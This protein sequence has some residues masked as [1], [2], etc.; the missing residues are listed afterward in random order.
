MPSEILIGTDLGTT[1]LKAAAFDARTRDVLARASLPL[2]AMNGR[3]G[4]REQ[5]PRAI[6]A[7][8]VDAFAQLRA[9]LGAAWREVSGIG[10]AAQGGSG[11]IVRRTDAEPL[12]PMMLWN[13]SR[14]AR[15]LQDV[16][17]EK[18]AEYWRGLALREGP[19]AG[20]G[21][22][23][24]LR[25]KQPELFCDENIYV[26]AGEYAYFLMTGVWRQDAGSAHQIGCYNAPERRIDP[27]PLAM[28]DL[29]SSF[30]A[31]LREG[32]EMHPV[33]KAG[34][35]L[36]GLP[37]GIAVAGP[38]FDH[39]AGYL[40]ALGVSKRPL[41]CSLGT[42][43][44]G[45][46]TVATYDNGWS[47]TQLVVPDPAGA[48][49]LVAQPLL[50]GNV[51]WNWALETFVYDDHAAALAELETLFSEALLPPDGLIALPWLTQLNA[52]HHDAV[53]A[54]GFYGVSTHTRPR[55][56][57]RAVAA[58]LA[59]EFARVFADVI[60][61]DAVDSVVLGGGAS[62]GSFFRKLFAALCAPLP[63]H[64]LKHQDMAG[65]RGALHAFDGGIAR[66]E[67][68]P[69]PAVQPRLRRRIRRSS[70]AYNK[71]FRRLHG[72]LVCGG[73]YVFRASPNKDRA[74]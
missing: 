48:G 42:A 29:P 8:L 73:P 4:A 18:P 49:W 35:A 70:A 28:V 17:R 41:Q 74:E 65:A 20:L 72:R 7:A 69:V 2:E 54:G 47:P 55:D 46:F 45:N 40:S 25:E 21:R 63:V 39:E 71:L 51:A 66:A 36:F 11:I 24:W 32:H 64:V 31:P 13:D 14:G 58:G 15:R 50:T 33:S 9:A 67:A 37:G 10:L 44:V 57:V 23:L 3:D 12:T 52:L 26:G 22:M 43:W 5:D 38:Y 30:V 61:S 19:G 6:K 56:F 60:V 1:N 53:G 16:A 68:V 34:A 59:C 62:N 27:E